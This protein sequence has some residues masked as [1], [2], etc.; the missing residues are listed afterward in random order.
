MQRGLPS[1]QRFT[2]YP[3]SPPR[4]LVAGPALPH[5]DL[6]FTVAFPQS[7]LGLAPSVWFLTVPGF[8]HPHPPASATRP[9]LPR[10]ASLNGKCNQVS[11]HFSAAFPRTGPTHL[12]P[13]QAR[14]AALVGELGLGRAVFS[15]KWPS[16]GAGYLPSPTP[17][18]PSAMPPANTSAATQSP[19]E[20]TAQPALLS[21][22]PGLP[23]LSSSIA[24]SSPFSSSRNPPGLWNPSLEVWTELLVLS[25]P[26]AP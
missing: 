23:W 7:L 15:Q 9:P 26:H 16:E 18:P 17:C 6:Q 12:P 10:T 4:D 20:A 19:P 24:R 11:A 25:E 13:R 8:P 5:Q 2:G 14:P 1:Q 3:Q 22:G 21:R